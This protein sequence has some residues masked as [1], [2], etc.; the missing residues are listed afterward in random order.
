MTTSATSA[1]SPPE[2]EPLLKK[3]LIRLVALILIFSVMNGTMF[4]VAIPDIA[5]HFNLLPSQ[6]SWV[7]TGYIMVNAVGA[8]M[9]GKLAD[10]FPIR[11][12]LTFGIS[13]LL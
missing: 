10:I 13:M 3:R 9:Y 4:N 2:L 11:S 8:L 5:D 12:I 6:V 7:M 1:H